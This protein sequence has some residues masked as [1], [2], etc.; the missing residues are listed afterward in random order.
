MGASPRTIAVTIGMEDRL[1]LLLQQHRRCGLG[2]P[3]RRVRHAEG[4]DPRPMVLRYLHRPHRPR[5][6][7]PRGHPIPQPIKAIPFLAL[8]LERW[9]VGDDTLVGLGLM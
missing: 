1:Q 8:R 4:P 2:H 5:E 7:T 9:G 3:V 6:V